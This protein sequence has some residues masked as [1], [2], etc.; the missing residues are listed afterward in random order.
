M[1][2]CHLKCSTTQ[3]NLRHFCSYNLCFSF[4]LWTF[5]LFV[6]VCICVTFS[7]HH[8]SKSPFSLC[9]SLTLGDLFHEKRGENGSKRRETN[10]MLFNFFI[11]FLFTEQ[12]SFHQNY[13]AACFIAGQ[14]RMMGCYCY[15]YY[16]VATTTRST[17][18]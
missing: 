11:L 18:W 3:K 4:H 10:F 8:N 16:Y 12:C 6:D 15:C 2:H 1:H 17:L 7:H 9:T 14:K 5:D 13:L